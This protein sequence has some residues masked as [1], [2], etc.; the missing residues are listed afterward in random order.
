MTDDFE[1]D[2]DPRSRARVALVTGGSR[3]LGRALAAGLLE[4]GWEVV[5]DGRDGTTLAAA[6]RDL[7]AR[8]RLVAVPGDVSEPRHREELL[9]EVMARGRL[10]LLVNNASELGPTPLPTLAEVPLSAVERVFTVNL[11][12]PLALIQLTL[13]LLRQS[14]GRVVNVSSD[15]AVEA[16]PGWGAYAAA[17]AALDHLSAV[18]AAEEPAVRVYAVDPG[19][20]ATDLH[21]TAVPDQNLDDLPA[22]A[23]VVPSLLRLIEGELASGRYRAGHL[24]PAVSPA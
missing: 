23:S 6:V 18:L 7:G 21:R 8:Q 2:G 22:P 13:P 19:D 15:A 24:S 4:Q 20:M 16:Y 17:K 3:G 9:R 14:A 5:I 10:D 1:T 11:L 12:A